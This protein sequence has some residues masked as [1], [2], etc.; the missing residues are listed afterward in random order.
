MRNVVLM[1]LAAC[2]LLAGAAFAADENAVPAAKIGVV[3][4][5]T[6]AT[7][8]RARPGRQKTDG[9]QIRQGAPELG[10]TGRSAEEK[11]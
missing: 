1:T 3:D 11:G 7:Q 9:I 8:S 4:M 5:Q 6:V 2:L 10:K